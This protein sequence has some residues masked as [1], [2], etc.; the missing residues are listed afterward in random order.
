MRHHLATAAIL[1]LLL[2]PMPTI[3]VSPAGYSVKFTTFRTRERHDPRHR[4][5]GSCMC[6]KKLVGARRF[7]RPTS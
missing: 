6:S 7:E 5:R 4:C 2:I 3:A 1:G